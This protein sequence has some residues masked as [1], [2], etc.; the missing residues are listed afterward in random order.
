MLAGRE[1]LGGVALVGAAAVKASAALIAPFALLGSRRPARLLVAGGLAIAA[2]IA[3]TVIV[4]DTE[5]FDAFSQLGANQSRPSHYGIPATLSRLTGLDT[6][7]IRIV[8]IVAYGALV[9]SLLVWAARGGDWLRAAGWATLGLLVA[10]AS[11]TPWYLIWALPLAA[12]G[13]DRVLAVATLALAA[14]E[15]PAALPL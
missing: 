3:V 13:R 10:S 15:L 12:V 11:I 1:A 14:Y 8:L 2:L 9:A 6:D 4:F 5:A 7:P